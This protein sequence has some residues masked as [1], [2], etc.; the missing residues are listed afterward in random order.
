MRLFDTAVGRPDL[1]FWKGLAQVS[2]VLLNPIKQAAAL[3]EVCGSLLAA[4][5]V[6]EINWEFAQ[7]SEDFVFWIR[8]ASILSPEEACLP[9]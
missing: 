7:T 2:T 5:T 3:L 6:A 8:V 1:E 4:R 9:N